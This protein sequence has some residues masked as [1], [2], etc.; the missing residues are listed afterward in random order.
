MVKNAGDVRDVGLIPGLGT[1]PG[2]GNAEGN[3]IRKCMPI[4]LPGKP[5]EQGN[6][7]GYN[8]WGH[9]ESDTTEHTHT[10][11]HT[12]TKGFKFQLYSHCPIC[13]F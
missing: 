10:H 11:T 1:S 4:F 3:G 7:A 6:L 9:K 2:E 13:A 5:H 8:S 12:Y